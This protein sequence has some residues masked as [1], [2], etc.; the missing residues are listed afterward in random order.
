MKPRLK[1]SSLLLLIFMLTAPAGRTQ[2]LQRPVNR[3]DEQGQRQGL[4][5]SYFERDQRHRMYKMHYRDGREYR[6][7]RYYYRNGHRRATFRYRNDSVVYVRYYDSCGRLN[8]KGRSLILYTEKEIR[9]CWDGLWTS[10]DASGH[11]L[12]SVMY[13]RGEEQD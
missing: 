9:Y 2:F 1:A 4:W 13:R 10:Y 3:L 12:S 8:Q 7:S 5:V 6:T 11:L